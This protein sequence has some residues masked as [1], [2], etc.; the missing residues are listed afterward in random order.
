MNIGE[1]QNA[2]AQL[3]Q[4]NVAL[5]DQNAHLQAQVAELSLQVEEKKKMP[6]S[7]SLPPVNYEDKEYVLLYFN[8]IDI[9]L[10][11]G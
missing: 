7:A 8:F 4:A 3:N 9:F 10:A 6:T 11:P 2:N 5:T 1:L